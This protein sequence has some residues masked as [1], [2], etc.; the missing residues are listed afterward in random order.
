MAKR[1]NT[2]ILNP[3]P[4]AVDVEIDTP[5]GRTT[6]HFE[7]AYQARRYYTAKDKAGKN[8]KV[9]AGTLPADAPTA[10]ATLTTNAAVAS[11]AED[12]AAARAAAKRTAAA[13][14]APAPVEPAKARDEEASK[15][16]KTPR[17]PVKTRYWH[18]AQI[19]KQ[20]GLE[21]GVLKPLMIDELNAAYGKANDV[22]SEIALRNAHAAIRSWLAD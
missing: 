14:P 3:A 13:T 21:V 16:A 6:K 7:D 11:P 19:I 4:A 1:K 5:K 8:P 10:N 12:R 20:H 2:A 15:E 18:A 22:E 9:L 17:T